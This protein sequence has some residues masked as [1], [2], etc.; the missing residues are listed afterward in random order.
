MWRV[1]IH[2]T[3]R[4]WT[5]ITTTR[6]CCP[7]LLVCLGTTDSPKSATQADTKHVFALRAQSAFSALRVIAPK[8]ACRAWVT[9]TLHCVRCRECTTTH[10]HA[11][12]GRIVHKQTVARTHTHTPFITDLHRRHNA[13]SASQ[14]NCRCAV[15]KCAG[16]SLITSTHTRTLAQALPIVSQINK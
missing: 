13:P 15:W 7:R 6:E 16:I 5:C 3:Q 8:D 9:S 14:T 11:H 2:G 10:T 1:F 12:N 4:P